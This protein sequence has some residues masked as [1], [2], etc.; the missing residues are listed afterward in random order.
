MYL[1]NAI[2]TKGF[3]HATGLSLAVFIAALAAISPAQAQ[4]APTATGSSS[5]PTFLLSTQPPKGA[6]VLLGGSGDTATKTLQ[7]N[8]YKRYSK[9]PGN[10]TVA[11]RVFTPQKTDLTSRQEFGDCYLHAEFRTPVV[12]AGDTN[13]HG[14]SGIGFQGRYEIQILGDYGKTPESHGS[15]SLYSQKASIVNASRKPGEWQTYDIIF[16]APRFDADGKVT[17]KPRA[18]V[19]H[20]GVLVQNNNEFTGMTGIQYGE[21]KEM[22]KTGPLVLQGDH[23]AVEYRNVWVVPLSTP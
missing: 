12:V 13:T 11:D 21:Y 8:W 6:V 7:E 20:N 10:W 22:A 19:F 3:R 5:P 15:A 1:Q 4:T 18:T 23:D 17:E 2:S 16:R 14:N 9:D